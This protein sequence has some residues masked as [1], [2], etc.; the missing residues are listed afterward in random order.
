MQQQAFHAGAGQM[1]DG[2]AQAASYEGA[3]SMQASPVWGPMDMCQPMACVAP[4][5]Q[6]Y[7]PIVM[8]DGTI[9]QPVVLCAADENGADANWGD[10]HCYQ[11]S[12]MQ[13]HQDCEQ[14][15]GMATQCEQEFSIS[16]LTGRVWK[17]SQDAKG[18]FQVQEAFENGTDQERIAM[19]S[20]L[21]GHVWQALKCG[22]ANHVIQ[23]C[24]KT[25][26]PASIQFIIEELTHNGTGGAAHAARHRF[27]CRIIERL[28]EHFSPEQLAP[29]VQEL[30]AECTVLA[31][32]IY[33][34][35]VIQHLLTHLGPD[36]AACI[37]STLEQNLSIMAPGGYVGAV[38]ETSLKKCFS[39]TADGQLLTKT[40]LQIESENPGAQ[41]LV[42]ALLNQAEY[43][44]TMACSRWGHNAVK[45]ALQLADAPL[46]EK[47]CANLTYYSS[48][49]RS[50]RYGRLVAR[51]IPRCQGGHVDRFWHEGTAIAVH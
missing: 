41:P 32:H 5:G 43:A 8:P 18:C 35:Y 40:A 22:H 13:M 51:S 17:L 33:G 19:A 37:N 49:L 4:D 15:N 14:F 44:A 1:S 27:G 9:L 31:S 7:Q 26:R 25:T 45:Y 16:P 30:L 34:Y 50:D 21:K 10:A 46:L 6:T 47:A 48:W 20:E 23:A 3:Q 28:I 12:G 29:L 42:D 36:V 38:I 11:Y 2:S 39:T 24:I